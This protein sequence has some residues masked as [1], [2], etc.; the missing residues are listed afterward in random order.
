MTDNTTRSQSSR[1]SKA[2]TSA[3]PISGTSSDNPLISVKHKY[4]LELKSLKELFYPE[5]DE[6]SLIMALQEVE[7]DI[8]AAIERISQGHAGMWHEVKKEHTKEKSSSPAPTPHSAGQV[9]GTNGTI[10]A[11]GETVAAPGR[12]GLAPRGGFRGARG[13]G[14]AGRGGRGGGRGGRGG[15]SG[16]SRGKPSPSPDV[17]LDG[18]PTDSNADGALSGAVWGDAPPQ[19]EQ[20]SEIT[21]GWGD[22]TSPSAEKSAEAQSKVNGRG[23]PTEITSSA[24]SSSATQKPVE[25]RASPSKSRPANLPTAAPAHAPTST[26]PVTSAAQQSK[27]KPTS[28]A[29][30]VKP[31]PPPEPKVVPQNSANKVQEQVAPKPVSKVITP[32]PKPSDVVSSLPVQASAEFPAPARESTE[33]KRLPPGLKQP[34]PPTSVMLKPANPATAPS[35]QPAIVPQ[36]ATASQP[37]K[38]LK[39]DVAVVMP[40]PDLAEKLA[41]VGVGVKFGTVDSQ[42]APRKPAVQPQVVGPNVAVAPATSPQVA[43]SI[44]QKSAPTPPPSAPAQQS[45]TASPQRAPIQELAQSPGLP[46]AITE[47]LAIV[48]SSESEPVEVPSLEGGAPLE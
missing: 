40:V 44:P 19:D 29:A 11:N 7:F 5:W 34:A 13:G 37:R 1:G 28:W 14:V 15:F 45:R 41:S 22:D 18:G 4:A 9:T 26:P 46:L 2:S 16:S 36:G 30:V 20:P 48:D 6:D 21:G 47:Q 17:S 12:G 3:Q 35:P 38:A 25:K 32:P 31:A 33:A 23:E 24:P 10:K 43:P 39:Q 27:A 8:D 42:E